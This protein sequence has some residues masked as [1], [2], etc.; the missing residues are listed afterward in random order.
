VTNTNIQ[1]L[2]Q[3]Q[4]QFLQKMA[5]IKPLGFGIILCG[6]TA[7]ARIYLHHRVSYDLDFFI[8]GQ[9]D[10]DGLAIEL[11][12]RGINLEDIQIE[13]GGRFVNQLFGFTQVKDVRLKISFIE[14]SYTGMFPCISMPIGQTTFMTESIEGL[15][16]RKL[17]TVSGSGYGDRPID[18]RQTARDL[19][20]LFMLDHDVKKIHDFIK[21]IN[22][23]SA[24]FPEKAFITGLASMPWIDMM[25]DFA[26]LEFDTTNPYLATRDPLN[27]M[28]MVK[29]RMQEVFKEMA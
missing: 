15:Y 22:K 21:E 28:A 10:P 24:N 6:G 26:Q 5:D 9:F 29:V 11:G 25:D 17:R 2:Y 13:S 23:Y 14:D 4:E 7:L 8:D 1:S 19:F 12:R 16:H 18:G 20:D 3:G 27:I